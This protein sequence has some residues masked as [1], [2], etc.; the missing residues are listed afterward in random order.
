MGDCRAL[1]A[2]VIYVRFSQYDAVLNL[3]DLQVLV[4]ATESPSTTSR[5]AMDRVRSVTEAGRKRSGC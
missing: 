4:R 1:A 5:Q 3:G 2:N